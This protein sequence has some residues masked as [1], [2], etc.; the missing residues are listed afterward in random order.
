MQFGCTQFCS[1]CGKRGALLLAWRVGLTAG[2]L[3]D[4]DPVHQI[5]QRTHQRQRLD[6]QRILFV[7]PGQQ[8]LGIAFKNMAKQAA[9]RALVG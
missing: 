5:H 9:L 4:G 2:Y 3:R 6:T 8:R 7:N 1:E